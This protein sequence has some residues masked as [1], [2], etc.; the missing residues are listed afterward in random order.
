MQENKFERQ[1][2]QKLSDLKLD[3]SDSVWQNIYA[4]IE[5]EKRRRRGL[6]IF[7]ILFIFFLC[8]GLWLWFPGIHTKR[9]VQQSTK[10]SMSEQNAT[11][12]KMN[13]DSH[14]VTNKIISKENKK[15]PELTS[16]TKDGKT[17]DRTQVYVTNEDIESVPENSS[18]IINVDLTDKLNKALLIPQN[19]ISVDSKIQ[20]LKADN[21]II[22]P[23][24]NQSVGV[25][26]HISVDP[27]VADL[28]NK[29]QEL[30]KEIISDKQTVS[31]TKRNERKWNLGINFS[32]GV[33]DISR[34]F[35]GSDFLGAGAAEKSYF[36]DASNLNT[37]IPQPGTDTL[38]SKKPYL[39]KPSLA[40]TIGF[41][42]D[43]KISKN[44]TIT[45]GINYKPFSTSNKVGEK[46]ESANNYRTQNPVNRYKNY[47]HFIE[48]PVAY[49][50]QLTKPKNIPLVL[51]A[52]ISISQL[53]AS[54]AVQFNN[55]S[56]IYY[57]D[58][59]LFNKTQ[60]GFNTGIYFSNKKNSIIIGP[61]IYYGITKIANQ[62]LYKNAHF[63]Y[64]GLNSKFLF[65]KK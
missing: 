59:S 10:N 49:S 27:V 57:Y 15:A 23:N 3:P 7:P 1:V 24:K 38:S 48:F 52:G 14:L 12:E 6:I 40:L 51:N 62:G 16:S 5:K 29:N 28:K 65:R 13:I 32:V 60:I 64:L 63:T 54:N 44:S 8:G 31:K 17:A 19:K 2:Q 43:K 41:F 30:K 20:D 37:G 58:N 39:I 21:K 4:K 42:A 46:N 22:I 26:N 55:T 33:S 61:H 45:L 9:K 47:Y 11:I 56:G 53:I 34:S 35:L 36:A 25:T 50:L 18:Y